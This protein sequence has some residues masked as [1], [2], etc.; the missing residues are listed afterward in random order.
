[1]IYSK[2]DI[3][4]FL[5]KLENGLLPIYFPRMFT[6]VTLDHDYNTR[7]RNDT[8]T[9][10][11]RTSSA[12]ET[13]RYYLPSFIR[14]IPILIKEKVHT[15]SFKGFTNYSKIHII[16]TYPVECTVP[17]C[18]ICN[19]W[20]TKKLTDASISFFF[21]SNSPSSVCYCLYISFLW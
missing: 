4:K 16:S 20:K 21:L 2:K 18:Y 7:R 8:F 13:I 14:D 11:P 3:F 10:V 19:L 17:H 5:Y 1:M 12:K 9:P 6:T 15:H